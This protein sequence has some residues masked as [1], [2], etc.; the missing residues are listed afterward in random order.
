[1][2]PISDPL[3]ALYDT[4]D[5]PSKYWM[6]VSE[7]K[8]GDVLVHVHSDDTL[9]VY[10]VGKVTPPARWNQPY[11]LTLV[12]DDAAQGI[13]LRAHPDAYARRLSDTD[14]EAQA[15]DPVAFGQRI[16][17][18]IEAGVKGSREIGAGLMDLSSG[19]GLRTYWQH[20]EDPIDDQLAERGEA[21]AAVFD[22]LRSQRTPTVPTNETDVVR[23]RRSP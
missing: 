23:R 12:A 11:V 2:K 20:E 22:T 5:Q 9:S 8:A 13:E 6:L 1:M 14:R 15:L 17:G 19:E 21:M 4:E 18:D 3:A 7:A 16:R 10:T